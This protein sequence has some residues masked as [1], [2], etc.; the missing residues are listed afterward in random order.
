MEQGYAFFPHRTDFQWAATGGQEGTRPQVDSYAFPYAGHL[1]MRTGWERDDRYLFMDAGPFGYGHQHEDKLN[2]VLYAYGK[3]L[4]A[5]PG[6]YP[7][8]DSPWRK[9]VLSTRGHNTIRVDG[10]DQHQR[11][12]PRGE[13]VVEEP[14]P[15]TWITNP[16]FDY[17]AAG[18]EEGYG[19]QFATEPA[20]RMVAH[21]RKILFVKP[22]FWLMADF[23][24][25]GDDAEHEAESL[26]H[27]DVEGAEAIGGTVRTSGPG[28]N[29][30]I[31]AAATAPMTTEI[32][33]GQGEPEV[34]GWIPRG[35]PY[36]CQPI[37]TAVF[38]S[39]WAGS[40]AVAYV[41]YPLKPG[42]KDPVQVVDLVTVDGGGGP[43]IGLRLKLDDN[44]TLL[45]A[46]RQGC[47]GLMRW[48]GYESDAEAVLLDARGKDVNQIM[49]VG[50]SFVRRAE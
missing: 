35:G 26:L 33:M 2:I 47:E 50:G 43:A 32:V 27:L 37:P 44:R 16:A 15:H 3:V 20:D 48:A 9:Y 34:Q 39:R 4:I 17:A 25:S 11:G 6:N 18:Y 13:Y 21:H 8:N 42:Q 7:Y 36:E 23:L 22:D 45:Y 24:L 5:D 38:R 40:V 14:L 10:Q 1:V 41:L 31:H 12:K 19:P 28:P 30:A 49:M 46:Q 29:L